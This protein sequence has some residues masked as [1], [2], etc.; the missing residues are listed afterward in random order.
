M[1]TSDDTKHLLRAQN[2]EKKL[3]DDPDCPRL[4]GIDTR[5]VDPA[6]HPH[7]DECEVC[8]GNWTPGDQ[9]LS[10]SHALHDESVTSLDELADALDGERA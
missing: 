4:S 10:L 5:P 1:P 7:T 6:N 2:S 9:D 8:A 3:H